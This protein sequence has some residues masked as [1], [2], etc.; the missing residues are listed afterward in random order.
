MCQT[1]YKKY[2]GIKKVSALFGRRPRVYLGN[3]CKLVLRE[4]YDT[5]P[6]VYVVNLRV[7]TFSLD[8]ETVGRNTILFCKHIVYILCT[9]L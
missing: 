7:G 8:C 6:V 2:K 3:S 9:T 5:V 4:D 1:K